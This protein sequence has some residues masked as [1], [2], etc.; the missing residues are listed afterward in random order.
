MWFKEKKALAACK[1]HLF[2]IVSSSEAFQGFYLPFI[3]KKKKRNFFLA[4]SLTGSWG[5]R[6]SQVLNS[7]VFSSIEE[8]KCF[9][10]VKWFFRY[11]ILSTFYL[12]DLLVLQTRKKKCFALPMQNNFL[13]GKI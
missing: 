6:K 4:S 5:W 13:S 1:P 10:R 3:K 2:A 7:E 8:N 12:K 11:F 9:E